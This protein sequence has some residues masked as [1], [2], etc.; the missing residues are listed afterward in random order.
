MKLI[1]THTHMYLDNFD[2]DRNEVIH[3]AIDT[4]IEKMLLPA[5]E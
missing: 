5:I 1:D 3:N 4:G 2:T